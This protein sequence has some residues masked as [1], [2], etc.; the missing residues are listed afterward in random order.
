MFRNLTLAPDGQASALA[1]A[2][3]PAPEQRGNKRKIDVERMKQVLRRNRWLIIL[4]IALFVLAAVLWTVI[5]TPIFRSTSSLQLEQQSTR[6]LKDDELQPGSTNVADAERFLQT[7]VDLLTNRTL[8]IRVADRLQLF[9]GTG[10]LDA[11]GVKVVPKGTPAEQARKRRERVIATLR[12]NQQVSL[13]RF[14][15]VVSITFSSRDRDLSAR[16]ANAYA[17]ALITDNL[18]RRWR[19][20]SYARDFL[21]GQLALA[22]TKL[23][24][25][26]R[27]VILYARGAGLIDTGPAPGAPGERARSLVASR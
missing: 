8:A 15:R 22:K 7:Q 1:L 16:V 5:A 10:F 19:A 14:S 9:R 4:C 24:A 17:E 6:V 12:N 11:M 21:E 23:E 18:E 20:S 13:P 25:S 2:P 27:A 3:P 26:E